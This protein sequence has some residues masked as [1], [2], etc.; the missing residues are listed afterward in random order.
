MRIYVIYSLVFFSIILIGCGI[1]QNR[2]QITIETFTN[3]LESNG[4]SIGERSEK[5]YG[6]LMAIDGY[7]IEVNGDFI[8]VYQFDT[9]IK[10]GKEAI[11]KWNKEGFMGQPVIVRK[12][13]MMF[14]N[15]NHK[16]WKQIENIFN[17]L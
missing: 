15:K 4:M 2:K 17:S 9:T 12:N 10:S 13:L 16:N 11:E 3:A 7:G 5:L 1:T 14:L 6:L 8:E